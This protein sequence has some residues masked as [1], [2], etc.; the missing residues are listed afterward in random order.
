MSG[1]L[2]ATNPSRLFIRCMRFLLLLA[3]SLTLTG[4]SLAV[5]AQTAAPIT[6]S[7]TGMCADVSGESTTPNAPVISW[8]CT[9]GA[10]QQ[11][12]PAATGTRYN[13]V[14]LNSGLCMDVS[15]QSLDPGG[16]IIQWTCSGGTN[17]AFSLVPQ[18]AGYAIIAGHSGLCVSASSTTSQGVQLTQQRCNGSATQTWQVSGL[19]A[20]KPPLP[21]KW[22]APITLPLVP[23]QAANLPDGTVLVWSAD[24]ALNFTTGEV[25]PGKTYT[26][27]FNPSTGKSKQTIVSNTGHDMFCPGIANLPDGRIFVTG[28]SNTR[29]T[30]IY[31]PATNAWTV[32]NQMNISRGYQG[33]VTLSNGNVFLVGGSWNGGLGGKTGET[34]TPGS[35][36]QINGAIVDDYILTNDAAGVFRADNHAWMFAVANG[37]VFHAGPS[38]AMH[39]FDTAGNGSVTAAGNRG[40]DSDAMNGNAVMYDIGKILTVGGAPSYDQSTATSNATLI[41][42]SSGTAVTRTIAPMSYQRAF[43]NSVVLP[44]GQVVVVGGQTFAAPFSDDNAILT[45]EIWDPATNAF[46]PLAPQAVPRTYHSI[47]ILLTDGRVLSGGGGLCGSCATNHTDVEILTPPYLL[48]ADGSAAS[49]PNLNSVPTDAQLGTTIVVTA[50][51]GVR[52]F[53]LM[54]S[55]SV[56]HSLNNEQRRVPLKYTVG[57]AGE[58]HLTIPSDPGVVIPGY[59]MLFALNA[60]GVPSVS[61]T[62]RVH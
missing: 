29:K 41:D 57:T 30:S 49:R 7:G 17:Q 52:A 6:L 48:N 51:S 33:S 36:W 18:G 53:A 50:S 38:R 24:S 42:I 14:N 47:A 31:S 9:G 39:W 10:N 22:S 4:V 56:T 27:I 40:N 12:R 3:L 44:N 58:Y 1:I 43:N 46:S 35:G 28:G 61:R 37:R 11:W 20:T 13:L 54:R 55:S 59:Y 60:K 19:P 25:T 8:P 16:P 26:A 5:R 2:A 21:S 15:G 23:L 34:W 62:L 45:P 32:S